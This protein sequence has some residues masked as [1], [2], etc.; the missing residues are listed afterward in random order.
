[1]HNPRLPSFPSLPFLSSLF[2]ELLKIFL[3]VSPPPPRLWA[4]CE[5]SLPTP[6]PLPHPLGELQ[7][8][9]SRAISGPGQAKVRQKNPHPPQNLPKSLTP[10]SPPPPSSA[11]GTGQGEAG[12]TG[13]KTGRSC[14]LVP[15]HLPSSRPISQEPPLS[16]LPP[17]R[18]RPALS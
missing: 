7:G 8:E 14:P 2:N 18:E 12:E 13:G 15:D 4:K 16:P 9:R 3:A 1:M 10:Y 6:A 5:S 17:L 11:T